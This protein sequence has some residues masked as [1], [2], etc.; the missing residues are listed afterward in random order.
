MP[1]VRQAETYSRCDCLSA[2]Y[3]T[4]MEPTREELEITE[5]WPADLCDQPA[6]V[7][8]A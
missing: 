5:R 6:I 2:P 4:A 1:F 7:P 3:G 8:A